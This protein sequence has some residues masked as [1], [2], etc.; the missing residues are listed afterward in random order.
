MGWFHDAVVYEVLVPLFKDGDGD[1]VGDLV[2]L[3]S[4]LDYL[5]DLGVTCVWL[6]P[7]FD[8]P[9]C[10]DGYDVRDYYAIDP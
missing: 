10:D 6:G 7:F 3:T 2:G 8:S 4:Q 9:R 1:G 5:A